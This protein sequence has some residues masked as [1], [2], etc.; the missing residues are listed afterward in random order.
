M[1]GEQEVGAP[2]LLYPEV[3]S[4]ESAA[5]YGRISLPQAGRNVQRQPERFYAGSKITISAT[6]HQR[7]MIDSLSCYD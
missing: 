4:V 1:G 2:V 7:N 5:T 6:L 3:P